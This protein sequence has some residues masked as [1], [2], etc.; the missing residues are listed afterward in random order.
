MTNPGQQALAHKYLNLSAGVMSV[1][2]ALV[3]VGLKFW[4]LQK[5][6]A[7]SIAATLAD[8]A[9]DLLVSLGGLTAIAYAARPADKDHPFGH[10]SAEDLAALLQALVI[11]GSA[12]SIIVAAVKRLLAPA[13]PVLQE[14]S[15]GMIVLGVSVVLTL[16]LVLW[17]R[18]VAKTTGNKVVAADSLHYIGDLIPNIA[19]LAALALSAVWNLGRIDA[20]VAALAGLIMLRGAR[21]IGAGAW[22]ALMDKQ[23]DR[24]IVKDIARITD[25]FPGILGHHDLKTRLSGSRMFGYVHVEMDGSQSLDAAHKISAAL[26]RKIVAAYPNAEVMIH[27]DPVGVE[28]HPEDERLH[29]K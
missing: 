11:T 15:T 1:C 2:I 21:E 22:N 12:I 7:L 8:S 26:R 27:K 14:E 13:T 5:T 4:A 3:L 19:A 17:Q 29:Q 23:A 18:F 10:T 16:V 20:V 6:G 9:M 28:P 25:E 24:A